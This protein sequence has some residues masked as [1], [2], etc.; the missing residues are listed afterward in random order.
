MLLVELSLLCDDVELVDEADRL[1]CELK[2]LV[3]DWLLTLDVELTELLELLVLLVDDVDEDELTELLELLVL[4]VDDVDEDELDEDTSETELLLDVDDW[5]LPELGLNELDELAEL[6]ELDELDEDELELSSSSVNVKYSGSRTS[7]AAS[8]W[9]AMVAISAGVRT[10]FQDVVAT[11]SPVKNAVPPVSAF[12]QAVEIEHVPTFMVVN[13]GSVFLVAVRSTPSRNS[14]RV[15]EL[16]VNA[17][18]C[19]SESQTLAST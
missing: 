10:R 14:F 12:A 11:K 1:D 17:K 9:R 3:D 18:W 16:H 5:L 2:E 19:Q 7:Y 15:P 8:G 6:I 13:A 4:L